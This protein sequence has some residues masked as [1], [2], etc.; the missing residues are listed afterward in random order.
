MTEDQTAAKTSGVPATP[1]VLPV[2]V[3]TRILI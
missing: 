1:S 2:G 3:L